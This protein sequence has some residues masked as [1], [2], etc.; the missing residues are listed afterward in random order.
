MTTDRDQQ[1]DVLA[2]QIAD[3]VVIYLTARLSAMETPAMSSMVTAKALALA[4]NVGTDYIYA[5]ADE[6]GATRIGHGAKPRL[7]FDLTTAREAFAKRDQSQTTTR[8]RPR[9]RRTT[10]NAGDILQIKPRHSRDW[11]GG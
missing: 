6:L 2:A 5:H 10:G 1:L 7:R 4:L 11:G 9:A 8:P 3:R